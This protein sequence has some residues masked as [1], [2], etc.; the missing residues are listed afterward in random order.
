MLNMLLSYLDRNIW[1]T[2][3]KVGFQESDIFIM[4]FHW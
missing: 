3:I 1:T 2:G 4:V